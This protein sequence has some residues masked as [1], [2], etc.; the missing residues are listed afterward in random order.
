MEKLS[1]MDVLLTY[2]NDSDKIAILGRAIEMMI[3][4]TD[5]IENAFTSI[6]SN[7]QTIASAL[8]T[9]DEEI[10]RIDGDLSNLRKSIFSDISQIKDSVK[11]TVELASTAVTAAPARPAAITATPAEFTHR[12]SIVE[13]NLMKP[14]QIGK[15]LV[16]APMGTSPLGGG[17]SIRSAMM[18][19][20][21][22]RLHGSSSAPGTTDAPG[23]KARGEIGGGYIP[24][25][26]KPR[27]AQNL[28]GGLV[29]KMNK[30]LDEKFKQIAPGSSGPP[31]SPPSTIGPQRAPPIAPPSSKD[32]KKKDKKDK[33]KD[34]DSTDSQLSDLEKKIREKLG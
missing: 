15:S 8:T 26:Q 2:K 23:E 3:D 22:Q 12:T 10:K 33:K 18:A 30:L 5:R 17:I 24:S 7:I 16:G 25:I 29:S 20:I 4:Y 9:L 14:S 6:N 11:E 34:K 21:K 1:I 27:E 19:E 31:N 32:D 13:E 28:E